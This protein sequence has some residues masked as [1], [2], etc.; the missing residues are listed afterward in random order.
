MRTG[1]FVSRYRRMAAGGI[2]TQR[3]GL[4][5]LIIE[6]RARRRDLGDSEKFA[7]HV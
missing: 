6:L 3:G 2:D 4:I 5:E 1:R 7:V